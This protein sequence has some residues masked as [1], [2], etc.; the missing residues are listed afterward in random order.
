MSTTTPRRRYD[1][2]TSGRVALGVTGFAG[3][4]LATV[5]I[6]QI[7]QGIAALAGDS[8]YPTS[9]DYAF[10]MSLTAWGWT[11]LVIGA[12]G[13]ATGVGIVTGQTWGRMAGITIAVFGAVSGFAF[14]PYYPG[15]SLAIVAFNV[16]VIWGLSIQIARNSRV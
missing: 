15:W 5:A 13:L 3:T 10:E 6:F 1:E 12:I 9:I 4:M 8:V 7:L 11:H 14:L 16:L 2:S